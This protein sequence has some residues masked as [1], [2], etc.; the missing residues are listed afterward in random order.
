MGDRWYFVKDNRK[1]GQPYTPGDL[2]DMLDRKI[3]RGHRML[4]NENGT[5]YSDAIGVVVSA[6]DEHADKLLT[7][8][9]R[10]YL[11]FLGYEG[12][13]FISQQECSDIIE[14]LRLGRAR[15]KT[16]EG[17][18]FEEYVEEAEE[19]TKDYQR[20]FLI[21]YFGKIAA[22]E[23]SKSFRSFPSVRETAD[24]DP[25]IPISYPTCDIVGPTW[26]FYPEEKE[27]RQGP[28]TTLELLSLFNTM[29]GGKVRW[30]EEYTAAA[31]KIRGTFATN[32]Q[33]D[34][35]KQ[36][37]EFRELFPDGCKTQEEADLAVKKTGRIACGCLIVLVILLFSVLVLRVQWLD[38]VFYAS[39][40]KSPFSVPRRPDSVLSG[41]FWD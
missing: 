6:L 4:V 27:D 34:E 21:H 8:R 29:M 24:P 7:P 26:Y 20:D 14:K 13:L 35:T 16:G 22:A 39:V 19:N 25:V 37:Y 11:R 23:K 17:K 5:T 3:I 18:P 41:P 33:T 40:I 10:G 31:N 28:Y 15:R 30:T 1:T 36:A 12:T 9:Q 2:V 32:N 38:S